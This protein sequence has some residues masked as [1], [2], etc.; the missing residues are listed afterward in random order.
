[1]WLGGP[2]SSSLTLSGHWILRDLRTP[3]RLV[4]AANLGVALRSSCFEMLVKL[5]VK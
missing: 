2:R 5:V 3:L 4:W 1:M